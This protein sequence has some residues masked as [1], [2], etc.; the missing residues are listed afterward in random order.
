MLSSLHSRSTPH[1]GIGAWCVEGDNREDAHALARVALYVLGLGMFYF[2]FSHSLSL[3]LTIDG[4][5]TI[6][7]KE[8]NGLFGVVDGW[9]GGA[10]ADSELYG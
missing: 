1:G 7:P 5:E 3:R 6:E 8:W 2:F 4:V 9:S 10:G